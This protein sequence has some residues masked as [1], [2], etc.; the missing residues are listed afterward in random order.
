LLSDANVLNY[1]SRDEIKAIFADKRGQQ[2]S[3]I[4]FQRVLDR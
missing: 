3:D 2:F 1:I 4:I